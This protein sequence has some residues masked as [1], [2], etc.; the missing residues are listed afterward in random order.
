M[1]LALLIF[2]FLFL[3]FF[4]SAKPKAKRYNFN[5]ARVNLAADT[6]LKSNTVDVSI[7]N[8]SFMV[9]GIYWAILR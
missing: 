6:N 2:F 7:S 8:I 3:S 4:C 5:E 1:S 9:V